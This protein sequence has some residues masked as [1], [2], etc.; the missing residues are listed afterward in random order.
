MESVQFPNRKWGLQ[1]I[2]SLRSVASSHL[3]LG[4]LEG[5][6]FV[7]GMVSAAQKPLITVGGV[8]GELI[9]VSVC[10]AL[11]GLEAEDTTRHLHGILNC[12][13]N[14]WEEGN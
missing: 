2:W 5:E 1:E 6:A 10:H 11:Q 13:Q 12:R 3:L 9:F 8:G 14:P 4:E 7:G